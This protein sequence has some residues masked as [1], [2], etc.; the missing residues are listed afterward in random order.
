M[1]GNGGK[2]IASLLVLDYDKGRIMVDG[3]EVLPHH[4]IGAEPTVDIQMGGRIS[5][6]EIPVWADNILVLAGGSPSSPTAREEGRAIVRKG[7]E[8]VLAWLGEKP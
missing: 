6:V 3:E 4:H 8:G 7:L 1:S 5:L 2:R